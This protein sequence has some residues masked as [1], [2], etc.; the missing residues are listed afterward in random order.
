MDKF[1]VIVKNVVQIKQ[2]IFTQVYVYSHIFS[3]HKQMHTASW[4]M[5]NH[6]VDG[7]VKQACSLC[8]PTQNFAQCVYQMEA[9]YQGVA[10]TGSTQSSVKQE[11]GRPALI[12]GVFWLDSHL[13]QAVLCGAF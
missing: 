9:L 5:A 6:K 8:P 7:A 4:Q 1:P 12:T 10:D 11:Y 13:Y 3:E 2:P